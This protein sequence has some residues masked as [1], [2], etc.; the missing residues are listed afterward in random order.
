MAH[1]VPEGLEPSEGW[2][3]GMTAPYACAAQFE[4]HVSATCT[5]QGNYSLAGGTKQAIDSI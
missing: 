3:E 2:L 1:G 5:W 4:G